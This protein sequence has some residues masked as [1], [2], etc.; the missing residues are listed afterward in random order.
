MDL[1][2]FENNGIKVLTQDFKHPVYAQLFDDFESHMSIVDL[3]F[4]CGPESLQ[5]IERANEGEV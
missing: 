5:V 4:N 3:L 1:Q 2:R